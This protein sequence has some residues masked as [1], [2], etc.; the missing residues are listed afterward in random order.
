[1]DD[2]NSDRREIESKRFK[3]D[4]AVNIGHILTTLAMALALFSWGSNVNSSVAIVKVEVQNI[5]DAR[6]VSRQETLQALIEINRKL[7]DMNK[8]L[9]R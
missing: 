1:M 3:F 5:K 2:N 8:H 9:S 4:A 6:A 7:D